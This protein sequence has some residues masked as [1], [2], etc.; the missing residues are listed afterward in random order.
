MQRDYGTR[1]YAEMFTIYT[2]DGQ[3]F[4]EVRRSPHL[5]NNINKFQVLEIGSCHLRLHN[6]ACYYNNAGQILSDFIT[7]HGYTFKRIAR[8]DLALDFEKFDSGDL[9]AK[10]VA[11]Y[12]KG[13]YAKVNQCSINFRSRYRP[14]GWSAMELYLLGFEKVSNLHPTLQQDVRVKA[15][16]RQTLH[17]AGMGFVRPR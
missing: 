9:P 12:L 7:T 11:R 3:P 17:T 5:S 2:P 4:L 1:V 16:P 15:S 10:F 13:V 14:M 6:R 8:I